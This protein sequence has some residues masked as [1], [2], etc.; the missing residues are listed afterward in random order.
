MKRHPVEDLLYNDLGSKGLIEL[1]PREWVLFVCS[2]HEGVTSGAD[3]RRFVSYYDLYRSRD[4]TIPLGP[5]H[6]ER[7]FELSTAAG[8]A[9]GKRYG[10]L[11]EY[12]QLLLEH[13][14]SVGSVLTLIVSGFLLLLVTRSARLLSLAHTPVPDY[15]F[16]QE[17]CRRW[18]RKS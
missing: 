8:T 12:G 17:A 2:V 4:S 1:S 11:L 5:L 9:F 3:S 15:H 10:T 13:F 18:E 6:L 16:L 7:V 14:A